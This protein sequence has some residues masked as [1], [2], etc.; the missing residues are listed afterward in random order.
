MAVAT[1]NNE[2][3]SNVKFGSCKI[4]SNPAIQ[5]LLIVSVSAAITYGVYQLR[6]HYLH[7]ERNKN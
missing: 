7:N 6:K 5:A 4:I 1:A 2:I 3:C